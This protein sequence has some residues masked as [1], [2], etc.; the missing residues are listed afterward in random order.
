MNKETLILLLSLV[1]LSNCSNNPNQIAAKANM[2]KKLY[3]TN[4]FILTTYA[5][6]SND[7][8]NN[9]LPIVVYIEGDGK[10]WNSKYQ[11]SK[12]PTPRKPLTLKLASLDPNENVIYIARPCQFTSLNLDLN[13][14][15]KYWS[16]ARYSKEVVD[17]VNQVIDQFKNTVYQSNHNSTLELHLV[18]YSGG[19]TI[20]GLIAINRK[21][22]KTLRTIAG[23]LDHDA[24]SDFHQTTKLNESLNLINFIEKISF[25]PQIHYIGQNDQ[26][27]PNYVVKN[28][29]TSINKLNKHLNTSCATYKI[30]DNID[31]YHGWEKTWERI[32]NIMPKCINFN[33]K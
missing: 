32:L 25:L 5:R 27:I 21:D 1:L 6:S 2:H 28:F 19:A 3:K 8:T 11:L 18:G 7:N 15:S 26:I 29:V 13:C 31:H 4:K 14:S 22:V 33:S 23:N 12:N 16:K 10:A 24:V 9:H 20:A 30:F 17:S